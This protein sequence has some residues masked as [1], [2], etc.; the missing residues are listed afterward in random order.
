MMGLPEDMLDQFV[1]WEGDMLRAPE[2]AK[3]LAA[4]QGIMGNLMGFIAEQRKAPTRAGNER[5]QIFA[6]NGRGGCPALGAVAP[7][8]V[9]IL[10]AER[11][12]CVGCLYAR[13]DLVALLFTGWVYVQRDKLSRFL[14]PPARLA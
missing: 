11:R 7:A 1:A 3:R 9:A 4:S 13:A 2:E 14:P 5:K 6:A 8:L 10:D 12:E